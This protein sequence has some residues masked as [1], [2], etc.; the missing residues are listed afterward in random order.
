MTINLVCESDEL[1]G[2]IQHND[3]I[4]ILRLIDVTLE[5]KLD[6]NQL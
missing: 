1:Q 3:L 5:R 2:E 4:H 6:P